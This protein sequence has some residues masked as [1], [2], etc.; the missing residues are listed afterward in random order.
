MDEGIYEGKTNNENVKTFFKYL[1]VDFW[2]II[3]VVCSTAGVENAR[4]S[5]NEAR[6]TNPVN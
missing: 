1:T 2:G 4:E 3:L 6:E 5:R